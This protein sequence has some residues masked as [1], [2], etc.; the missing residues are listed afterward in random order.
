MNLSD[1]WE[2]LG[3]LEQDEAHQVLSRLYVTYEEIR[4]SDPD[5]KEA[6]SFFKNLDNAINFCVQCNLNRR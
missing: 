4:V 1:L 6:E 3:T 2:K 5:N